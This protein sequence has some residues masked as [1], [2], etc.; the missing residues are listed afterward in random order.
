MVRTVRPGGIVAVVA[1]CL[2]SAICGCRKDRA[3]T[4][5]VTVEPPA[6]PVVVAEP[7]AG[8]PAE[9]VQPEGAPEA[10]EPQVVVPEPNEA[11]PPVDLV[12]KFEPGQVATY[13]VTT[14][15]Q[16]KRA[17]A[18]VEYMEDAADMKQLGSVW[19][20]TV[21]DWQAK[22]LT[23]AQFNHLTTL[24]DDLKRGFGG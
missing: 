6:E 2:L 5:E 3:T 19:A 13:K 11:G 20:D 8:A 14:E 12:L 7:S 22:N 1:I 15:A 16:K 9:S 24:K 18:L 21:K 23:Q 4:P 17:A 10:P